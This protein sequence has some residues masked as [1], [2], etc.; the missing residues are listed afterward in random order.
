MEEL[1][2]TKQKSI[3]KFTDPSTKILLMFCIKRRIKFILKETGYSIAE[4]CRQSGINIAYVIYILKMNTKIV[5][6]NVVRHLAIAFEINA[7][8][9]EFDYYVELEDI[10]HDK[11]QIKSIDIHALVNSISLWRWANRYRANRKYIESNL[12]LNYQRNKAVEQGVKVHENLEREIT[13]DHAPTPQERKFNYNEA[14]KSVQEHFIPKE[15]PVPSQTELNLL[16]AKQK[17]LFQYL[18]EKEAELLKELESV[19]TLIKIYQKEPGK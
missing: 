8:R 18:L 13:V 6:D 1:V 3:Y 7:F 19:R 9:N 4:F 15:K 16:T 5:S 17:T 10:R 14:M 11:D 2:A 12:I